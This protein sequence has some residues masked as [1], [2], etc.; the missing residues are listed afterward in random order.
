MITRFSPTLL[1]GPLAEHKAAA[2]IPRATNG[3][4]DALQVICA[5]PFSGQYGPGSRVLYVLVF[6][7]KQVCQ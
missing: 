1:L 5:W 6:Y 2:I 3:T 7:P 4:V